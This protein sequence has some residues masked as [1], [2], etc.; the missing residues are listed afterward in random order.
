MA[1][2]WQDINRVFFDYFLH[3]NEQT[4][5]ESIKKFLDSQGF[6]NFIIAVIVI[7]AITLGL[8]TSPDMQ[9]GFTVLRRVHTEEGDRQS[10]TIFFGGV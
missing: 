1:I 6:Q 7:N 5:M 8:E 10:L 4:A 9:F 2:S 3:I